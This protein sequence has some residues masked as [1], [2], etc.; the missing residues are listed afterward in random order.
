[1]DQGVRCPFP[2]PGGGWCGGNGRQ[3][4]HVWHQWLRQLELEN[5]L[6]GTQKVD[7]EKRHTHSVKMAYRIRKLFISPK[8]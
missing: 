3:G 2:N 6:L 7:F 4:R 5:D 1:M 8:N